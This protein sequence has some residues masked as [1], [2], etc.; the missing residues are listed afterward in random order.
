ML[1]IIFRLSVL[2]TAQIATADRLQI[3]GAIA[4]SKETE[5]SLEYDKRALAL[6][7]HAA[8]DTGTILG[9]RQ[10]KTFSTNTA[11]PALF[12]PRDVGGFNGKHSADIYRRSSD[13]AFLP[14]SIIT[15]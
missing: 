1:L 7:G 2:N 6:N 13:S 3:E 12:I 9:V 10:T 8:F 5:P 15:W 11:E 4:N 14:Q